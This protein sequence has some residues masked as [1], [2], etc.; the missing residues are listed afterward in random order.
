MAKILLL[1]C[2]T[3]PN[4]VYVWGLWNQNVAINQ[5]VKSG[6]ILSWAAKY[7]GERKVYF[8]SVAQNTKK[9]MLNGIRK[10]MHDADVICH[11]NGSD[12]DIPVLNREFIKAGMKPPSP[13][14]QMDILL[15]VRKRFR[16]PSNKLEYICNELKIGSK[17]KHEGFPLWV[18]CM[19]GKSEVT[20]WRKMRKY[21]IG[22][23][24][25]L[26]KLY[27]LV[28]PWMVNHINLSVEGKPNCP[29]C[30]SDKVQSRGF[31]FTNTGKFRRYVCLSCGGWYKKTTPEEKFKKAYASC[32]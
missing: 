4:I 10:L 16:F 22:D 15:T 12:F 31:S 11:F 27:K 5:I 32:I 6:E 17:V 23:V 14:K 30:K 25:L 9:G 7:V 2:E 3:S 20:A 29:R 18:K 21:N 28:L 8:D 1:D 24:I 13:F 19:R 26:E